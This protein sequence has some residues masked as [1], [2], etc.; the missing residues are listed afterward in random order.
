MLKCISSGEGDSCRQ[1]LKSMY[2]RDRS[3][4]SGGRSISEHAFQCALCVFGCAVIPY[5][6][7]RVSTHTNLHKHASYVPLC[8]YPARTE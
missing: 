2:F 1:V 4:F 7:V 3:V 5:M 6:H 8:V